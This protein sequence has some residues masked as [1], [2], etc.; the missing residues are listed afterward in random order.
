MSEWLPIETAPTDGTF[1]VMLQPGKTPVTGYLSQ[2]LGFGW[3]S[4]P[5]DLRYEPT[6]W[7]PLPDGWRTR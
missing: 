6:H 5:G 2:C 7:M 1:I 3:Q 4:V